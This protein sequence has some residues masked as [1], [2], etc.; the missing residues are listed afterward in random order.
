[1]P[2]TQLTLLIMELSPLLPD[3]QTKLSNAFIA[4]SGSQQIQ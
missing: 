1:M 4:K 2:P 3:H